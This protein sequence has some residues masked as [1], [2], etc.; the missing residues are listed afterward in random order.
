VKLIEC[1]N[2]FQGEGPDTGKRILLCRFKYC[3]MKCYFCDTLVKM[4]VLQEATHKLSDLQ[5]VMD[6]QKTGI[7]VT[8]GEPTISKHFNEL[9]LMLNSLVYSFCNVETNGHRLLE[10]IPKVNPDKNI[11]FIYSPKIFNVS[12]YKKEFK[13]TTELLKYPNVY[14]KIVF[15][16]TDNIRSYLNQLEKFDINQRVFLMPEGV[17]REELL[18]NAP[19]V[20]DAAEK[21]KFNFSSRTHLIYDFV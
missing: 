12:D 21:Y 18:K 7:L 13:R 20:F 14:F 6:E 11:K 9:L 4:R 16:D 15:E 2:T 8:G 19:I 17:T 5:K 1:I 3:N 10:L